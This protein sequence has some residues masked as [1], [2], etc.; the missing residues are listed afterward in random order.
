MKVCENCGARQ[1]DVM[2]FCEQCK[3]KLGEPVSEEEKVMIEKLTEKNIKGLYEKSKVNPKII[4]I[5]SL[6]PYVFII[7]YSVYTAFIGIKNNSDFYTEILYTVI[8]LEIYF[9]KE[10]IKIAPICFIYQ[11]I[12]IIFWV[13]TKKSSHWGL[14]LIFVLSFFSYSL[15]IIYALLFVILFIEDFAVF[16]THQTVYGLAAFLRS[17]I[18][19]ICIFTV[20]PIL[21]ICFVHQIIYLIK[22]FKRKK[23]EKII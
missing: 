12:Y 14:K 20:I 10:I 2:I 4:F 19:S 21:P 13:K 6:I 7:L 1:S 16:Q 23:G 11:V 5:L 3:E 22:A 8:V 18:Y 9:A 17:V 15:L